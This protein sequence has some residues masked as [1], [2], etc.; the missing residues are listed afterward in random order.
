MVGT[1]GLPD[2]AHHKR[3]PQLGVTVLT[4]YGIPTAYAIDHNSSTLPR[5]HEWPRNHRP[6]ESG[7]QG[8]G[9]RHRNHGMHYGQWRRIEL[10]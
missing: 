8:I 5:I 10:H 7:D 1:G 4:S 2:Y 3:T 9:A 6:P